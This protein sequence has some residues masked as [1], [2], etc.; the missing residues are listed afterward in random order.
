[1]MA[2]TKYPILPLPLRHTDRPAVHPPRESRYLNLLRRGRRRRDS[3]RVATHGLRA[4]AAGW[5]SAHPALAS[6]RPRPRARS[7]SASPDRQEPSRRLQRQL[8]P[9]AR[10]RARAASLRGRAR[11]RQC[12]QAGRRG[13]R[14][15]SR[16][17]GTQPLPPLGTNDDDAPNLAAEERLGLG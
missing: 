4:H 2:T 11:G 14:A 10:R 5:A 13:R 12:G 15:L 8:L 16:V 17:K 9:R 3:R 7:A 6:P 1:M